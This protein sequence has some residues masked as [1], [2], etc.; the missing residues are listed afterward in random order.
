MNEGRRGFIPPDLTPPDGTVASGTSG[1]PPRPDDEA[2]AEGMA[3]AREDRIDAAARRDPDLARAGGGAGSDSVGGDGDGT[4]DGDDPAPALSLLHHLDELRTRILRSVLAIV[5]GA[6]VGW[7]F[8][9]TALEWAIHYTVGSVV[10]LDPLE[11]FNERIKLALVLGGCVALPLVLYQAWAFVLPGLFRRERRLLLPLVAAS[12]I[13]FFAGAAT[14]ILVV[15]PIVLEVLRTFL[16]PS[17]Q[18]Q[19]RLSSLLGFLYNLAL[20]TGVVFQLPLVA[21]ALAALRLLTSRWLV[22]Q[23]R[24]AIVTMLIVS[25]LITPGDVVTAQIVL[26]IPLIVLYLMSIAVAW[27]VE[28]L[29]KDDPVGEE[30]E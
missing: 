22:R 3:R 16:T 6:G 10:I 21:G 23:W 17:M 11:S 26:G 2:Q 7:W 19:I 18:Q 13:L 28:R 5:L 8:S 30:A 29:R 4:G 12:M 27:L 1:R 9:A 15:V 20:A 24:V 25:A 14:A